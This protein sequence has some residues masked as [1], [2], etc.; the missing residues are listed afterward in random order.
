MPSE[1]LQSPH[2]PAQAFGPYRLAVFVV[3]ANLHRAA[4]HGAVQIT[5][6]QFNLAQLPGDH[7]VALDQLWPFP[8]S[9]KPHHDQREPDRNE[10]SE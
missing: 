7:G 9:Y 5:L 1:P 8:N 3:K 10:R 6:A 4:H 2:V